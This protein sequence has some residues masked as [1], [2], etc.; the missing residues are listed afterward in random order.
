MSSNYERRILNTLL[1]KYERSKSFVGSNQVNQTFLVKVSSLF[2]KYIDHAN[3]E[4]FRDVNEAIDILVRKGLVNAKANTANVYNHIILRLDEVDS[5]YRYVDRN[6]KKDVNE[7]ILQLFERYMGQ[8]DILQ[9]FCEAQIQ[10]IEE[11]KNV[12]HFNDD[13]EE[14]ADVLKAVEQLLLVDS[15]TFT[16]DFSVRVFKDSKRFEQIRSK[17]VSILYE[18]GEFPDKEQILG[19]LNIIKN[20][21]Y[22]NFKGAGKIKI[23]GQ[24]LDLS[25][26]QGDI[27]VSS[28]MLADVEQVEVTGSAVITIENLTSF[29]T[30]C[31]PTM[32]AIY[33][34]GY[35]NRVRRE[36]I[37]NI[38][39]HNQTIQYYHFGDIDAGGY[40]ILEHLR[41]QTGVKFQPYKM[42]I[43]TLVTYQEYAKPLTKNDS[44]RLKQ[45]IEYYQNQMRQE[46]KNQNTYIIDILQYML[47]NNCKLEQEAIVL[48]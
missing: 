7:A 31:D 47:D 48:S 4:L 19:N 34:G 32:L 39:Q 17:V 45:L 5:V 37:K 11:N 40:Y 20:P 38:Y 8:N 1:D 44:I 25:L 15:E 36:F 13:I 10:R 22:V 9:R 18:Y 33:L 30:F 21:T 26:L 16:R 27:A 29:H 46:M 6:P 42:D 43:S 35:H 24:A 2:P 14:F 3:Y 23:K 28:A 12:Q 41:E